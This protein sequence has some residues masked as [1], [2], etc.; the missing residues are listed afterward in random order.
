M[1]KPPTG[2][3]RKHLMATHRCT[4]CQK[5]DSPLLIAVADSTNKAGQ[6]SRAVYYYHQSC[7]E[8]AL[9]RRDAHA[10][11]I[12]EA[13]KQVEEAKQ[14]RQKFMEKH[15]ISATQWYYEH[16]EKQ[17]DARGKEDKVHPE[18]GIAA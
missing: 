4:F 7:L 17:H 6:L 15:G 10:I 12:V 11:T 1:K 14:K 9:F 3:I 2:N 18:P 8:D 16:K 13:L 5:D